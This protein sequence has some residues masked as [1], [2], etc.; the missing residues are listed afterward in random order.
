M[1]QGV[2]KAAVAKCDAGYAA[3]MSKSYWGMYGG[4]N[5]TNYA[6]YRLSTNGVP[7]PGYNLGSANTWAARAKANKVPVDKTPARGSVGVWSGKNHLVYVE[8][9]GKGYLIIKEDNYRGYWPKGLFRTLKVYPGDASYPQQ[10]IHF[11]DLLDGPTPKISG[12][13]QVGERLDA[14]A[15][16]WTPSGVKLSYQWL[17]NGKKIT[18]ATNS[19]RDAVAADLSGALSV[20]VTGSRKNFTTVAKTSARTVAVAAGTL[21]NV[22]APVI[23][24]DAKVGST[25]TAAAGR[26]APTAVSTTYQWMVNGQ[27]LRGAT[28]PSFVPTSVQLGK[29][30]S[31]QISAARAGYRTRKVESARS[32]P[33]IVPP[34]FRNRAAPALTG[35]AV[36]GATLTTTNG[37]WTPKPSAYYYRWLRNGKKISG[38]A[39]ASYVLTK[40]DRGATIASRVYARRVG[41][42]TTTKTSAKSAA[43]KVPAKMKVATRAGVGTVK[44]GVKVTTDGQ[45]QIGGAVSLYSGKKLLTKVKVSNGKITLK[46]AKQRKG[47]HTYR[48]R[49]TGTTTITHKSVYTKVK[50]G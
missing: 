13:P 26:W 28:T 29:S 27:E 45:K 40:A 31:V 16:K 37:A 23:D 7:R 14:D 3:N 22:A 10:F 8:T 38:A 47:T 36:V 4:H 20:R 41:F 11:E 39:R 34:P 46:L 32:A 1:C 19:S 35:H 30:M 33:V 17:R 48:L 15:G 43:V 2:S 12:T 21:R 9:V 49:F 6:A 44:F 50:V 5:C 25:L 18:G 24:G 42:K